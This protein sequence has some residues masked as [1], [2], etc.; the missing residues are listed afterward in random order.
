MS[1]LVSAIENALLAG[2]WLDAAPLLSDILSEGVA[3]SL[4]PLEYYEQTAGSRCESDKVRRI[5]QTRLSLADNRAYARIQAKVREAERLAS[6]VR[7][8]G[9]PCRVVSGGKEL[10]VACRIQDRN[11]RWTWWVEEIVADKAT[12]SA[13]LGY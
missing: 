9:H 6:I 5:L 12:V 4:E 7:E 1:H 2:R 3:C 13:Y 10:R 11:G 8:H